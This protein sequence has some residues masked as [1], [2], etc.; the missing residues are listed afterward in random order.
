MFCKSIIYYFKSKI[1]CSVNIFSVLSQNILSNVWL[2]Y[3]FFQ[4]HL[5]SPIKTTEK[6][7]LSFK[8]SLEFKNTNFSNVLILSYMKLRYQEHFIEKT[9]SFSLQKNIDFSTLTP[10]KPLWHKGF[11]SQLKKFQLLQLHLL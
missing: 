10:L 1:K 5:C 11:Q 7:P 9:L 4:F 8:S 3:T 2:K 6:C